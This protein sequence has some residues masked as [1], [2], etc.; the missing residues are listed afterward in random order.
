MEASL[1]G[2]CCGTNDFKEGTNAFLEK[3]KPLFINK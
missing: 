1:F 3:R 2:L